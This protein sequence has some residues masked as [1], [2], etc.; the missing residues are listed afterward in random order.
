MNVLGVDI[1]SRS[2]AAIWLDSETEQVLR[3]R[4]QLIDT[5]L[6]NIHQKRS[7]RYFA[8][9]GFGR[10]VRKVD[11]DV[12]LVEQPMGRYRTISE[13]DRVT[14]A[15]IAGIA[16]ERDPGGLHVE[17]AGPSL[18]KKEIGLKGNAPKEE[19]RSWVELRYPGASGWSQDLC[20]AFAIAHAAM[21]LG[22]TAYG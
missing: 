4:E 16:G 18:W 2:I 5:G 11:T 17:L 13:Q 15:F 12:V 3:V 19:V 21:A 8:A 9:Y 10:F 14:G 1:G 7:L 22:L 20:D 6:G